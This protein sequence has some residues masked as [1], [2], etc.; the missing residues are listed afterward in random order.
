MTSLAI[1]INQYLNKLSEPIMRSSLPNSVMLT[2]L[3]FDELEYI[4]NLYQ[5]LV[6]KYEHNYHLYLILDV[7]YVTDEILMELRP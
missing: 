6:T 3:S 7:W 5:M 4:R 2:T 1:S